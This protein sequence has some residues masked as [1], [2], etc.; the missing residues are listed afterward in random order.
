MISSN[1]LS[2]E[3]STVVASVVTLFHYSLGPT[4]M[5][6]LR[7]VSGSSVHHYLLTSRFLANSWLYLTWPDAKIWGRH[8]R[9]VRKVTAASDVGSLNTKIHRLNV[10]FVSSTSRI[11]TIRVIIYVF[12]DAS[13]IVL[14]TFVRWHCLLGLHRLALRNSESPHPALW[15][16]P[17][18]CGSRKSHS[19]L[20]L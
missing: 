14:C 8:S 19:R 6:N 20:I 5:L 2:I 12:R 3:P 15:S 10:M 11:V 18:S 13:F 1:P 17:R 16:W 9:R 7:C 4:M